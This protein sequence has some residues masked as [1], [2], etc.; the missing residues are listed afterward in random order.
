MTRYLLKLSF[1]SARLY[2]HDTLM[3]VLLLQIIFLAC[4]TVL[5]FYFLN[6]MKN[7]I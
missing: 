3:V 7:N 4:V 1:V 5:L 6:S 2:V